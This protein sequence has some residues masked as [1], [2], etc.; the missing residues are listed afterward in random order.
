MI[1][2]REV[3]VASHDG[4]Q[5][6]IEDLRELCSIEPTRFM[7]ARDFTVEIVSRIVG[8]ETVLRFV[9]TGLDAFIDFPWWDHPARDISEWECGDLPLGTCK[10]PYLDEDQCWRILIWA[11]NDVVYIAAGNEDE[12]ELYDTFLTLPVAKYRK[13]WAE[14]ISSLKS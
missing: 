12:A 4:S 10:E 6:R 7:E 9:D 2:K 3:V 1:G 11:V 14:L 5:L 8:T 13:A